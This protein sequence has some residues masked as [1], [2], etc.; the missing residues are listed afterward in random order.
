MDVLTIILIV[1]LAVAL[2]VIVSLTR[3]KTDSAGGASI[4]STL[5]DWFTA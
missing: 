5:V 4:V 1:A 2:L 3:R